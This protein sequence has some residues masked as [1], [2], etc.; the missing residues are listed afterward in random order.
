MKETWTKTCKKLVTKLYGTWQKHVKNIFQNYRNVEP[1][2]HDK[3]RQK[4]KHFSPKPYQD[5]ASVQ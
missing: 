5:H 4:L 2:K 1:L 3:K